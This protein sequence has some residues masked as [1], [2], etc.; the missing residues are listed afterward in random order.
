MMR[1]FD[2]GFTPRAPPPVSRARRVSR[3]SRDT[4]QA[5]PSAPPPPVNRDRP[6]DS[7]DH[8]HCAEFRRGHWYYGRYVAT[9]RGMKLRWFA[10]SAFTTPELSSP[11][12]RALRQAWQDANPDVAAVAVW[13]WSL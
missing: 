10:S 9:Q 12:F 1:A 3:R 4:P 5:P 8:P 2:D 7:A 13:L 11:Q 6:L